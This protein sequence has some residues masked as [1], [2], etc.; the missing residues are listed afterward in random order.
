MYRQ[1]ELRIGMSLEQAGVLNKE[2]ELAFMPK[3][4]SLSPG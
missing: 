3:L 4:A 1:I 2:I